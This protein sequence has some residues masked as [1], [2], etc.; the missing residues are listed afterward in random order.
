M[1]RPTD[2]YIKPPPKKCEHKWID[3]ED[4]SL[5][6]FCV[7]CSNKAK[8]AVAYLPEVTIEIRMPDPSTCVMEPM[9]TEGIVFATTKMNIDSRAIEYLNNQILKARNHQ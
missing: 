3:M 9:S 4:G 7:R 1:D 6:K 2:I 8:Q 5:D